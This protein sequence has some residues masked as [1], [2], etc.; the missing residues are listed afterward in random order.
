MMTLYWCDVHEIKIII[1]QK[2][3]GILFRNYFNKLHSQLYC[4][5]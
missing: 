1:T 4:K 5:G 2:K 3:N